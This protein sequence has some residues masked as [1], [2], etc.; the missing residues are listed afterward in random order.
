MA[1]AS[2]WIDG[3]WLDSSRGVLRTVGALLLAGVAVAVWQKRMSWSGGTALWAGAVVGMA[4]VLFQT[5]PG[6]IW[7]IVLIIGGAV[8]AAAVFGGVLLGRGL[9][10]L[11]GALH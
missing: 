1:L 3:W 8:S 7:P 5:G 6:T 11:L 10:N 4:V 9:N 2:N